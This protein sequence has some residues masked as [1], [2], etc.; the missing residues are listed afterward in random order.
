MIIGS[1]AAQTGYAAQDRSD[2]K[3][4]ATAS[5]ITPLGIEPSVANADPHPLAPISLETLGRRVP[6]DGTPVRVAF[7][8]QSTYFQCCALQPE[9]PGMSSVFVDFR[10]GGDPDQVLSKTESFE[11]HVVFVFRPELIP[12]GLFRES[13]A[14]V[15]GY[16]TEPL[17]RA[18]DEPSHPDLERR[19]S[20][21]GELDGSNF[22]RIISFDPCIHEAAEKHVPLWRSVP[23][24]V[25]DDYYAAVRASKRPPAVL[26][27]GRS[28]EH[29]EQ[30]LVPCKHEFDLLHVA[31]GIGEESLL[32]YTQTSDI[33][34]NLHNEPYPT[35]ENRV[36][37]YL[38]AGLLV[39]T[40]PLS[41][42]HGLEP[43][44]D[45]IEV[46]HPDD[47]YSVL[48][49]ARRY[50]DLY[51]RVRIRGRRKA[52]WFRASSVYARL[53]K[54]LYLDLATFGSPR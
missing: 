24:P 29:R 15:V 4:T 46:Q 16:L 45:Y 27:L 25:R 32:D 44:I 48:F 2:E 42:T 52:E 38:A 31:H 43:E 47:L 19:A 3:V 28:T 50:P 40:E 18:G 13:K 35:F 53:I 33:G 34:I 23:L 36:S 8:G 17:P 1:R 6:V 14:V 49:N 12:P 51:R 10:A 5:R 22:D 30:F 11:P 20:L 9:L 21:L 41:P 7:V 26:F 37:L 54:D 39:V